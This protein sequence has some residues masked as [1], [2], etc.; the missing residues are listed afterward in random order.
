[1]KKDYNEENLKIF[2]GNHRRFRE[3]CEVVY[4]MVG[5]RKILE[6]ERSKY[7]TLYFYCNWVLH[8]KLDREKTTKLLSDIF[9][10]S[11][12]TRKSER[13]NAR[14]IKFVGEDFFKFE[15]LKKE[16]RDFFKKYNLPMDLLNK[17][18]WTFGKL[19][20]G[21]IKDCPV[22]FA[23]CKIRRLDI[24]KYDD[25]NFGY[26]FSFIDSRRKPVIKLKL[27]NKK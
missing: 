16:L 1:M 11:I 27:K 22:I 14:N 24:V 2:L 19:L 26:K 8:N 4:L 5:I 9:D 10:S 17:N 12:D 3:E 13:E 23:P 20:L 6:A 7:K 15:T 18:W 25:R 21:A